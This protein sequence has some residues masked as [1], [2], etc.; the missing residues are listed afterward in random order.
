MNGPIRVVLADDHPMFRYGVVAAL[1]SVP[2]VEIVGEAADGRE[3]VTLTE[4]TR[5]DV[6]LTD[7][8]M[9]GLDGPGAMK[10]IARHHPET[11]VLV[12]TMHDD[13]ESLFE[14]MQAGAKGYLVKGADRAEIVAA[15]LGVAAG[16]AVYGQ[17]IAR[18]IL[19]TFRADGGRA[20]P[21][22][23]P[24]LTRREQD[25]LDLLAAGY[26]NIQMA[27]ELK[28]AEKTIRNHIS[29]VLLKL[30]VGDRT[31]AALKA[32]AAGMGTGH[33]NPGRVNS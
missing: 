26:R 22:G 32:R 13:D 9:P 6:V 17:P 10:I 28:L 4:G 18:R 29:S 25:V 2:E 16:D 11:A 20:R 3:L 27:S 31:A 19:E 21:P 15:I 5:P 1:R 7:L 14:A 12:L 33:P 23:L 30:Q 24:E 8:T